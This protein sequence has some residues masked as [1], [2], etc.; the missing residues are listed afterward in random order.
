MKRRFARSHADVREG[1]AGRVRA[2]PLC[3]RRAPGARGAADPR[4]LHGGVRPQ[5]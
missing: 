1:G 2:R 5:G 3:R 4:Q